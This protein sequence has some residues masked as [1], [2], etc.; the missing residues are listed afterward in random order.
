MELPLASCDFTTGAMTALKESSTLYVLN[1]NSDQ[2]GSTKTFDGT[3]LKNK[4]GFESI[5]GHFELREQGE[6]PISG[7]RQGG[8]F[9]YNLTTEMKKVG[10]CILIPPV[11]DIHQKRDINLLVTICDNN[12]HKYQNTTAKFKIMCPTGGW[13]Q[14][15]R[16]DVLITMSPPI[17]SSPGMR[18]A[19][20][21]DL[22][23]AGQAEWVPQATVDVVMK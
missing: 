2:L 4:P 14:G 23:A 15:R 17:A 5:F 7:I 3:L 11:K 12:G 1:D 21:P 19:A 13:L 8:A 20:L 10:D 6:T 22:G 16:Y 18:A 9:K